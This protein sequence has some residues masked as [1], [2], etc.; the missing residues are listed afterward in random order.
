LGG[1]VWIFMYQ[2][3]RETVANLDIRHQTREYLLAEEI[4]LESLERRFLKPRSFYV[5]HI[6]TV[7]D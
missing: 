7:I 2:V 3:S 5:L 4:E 6:R 1:W